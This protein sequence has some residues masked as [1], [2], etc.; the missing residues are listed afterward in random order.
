MRLGVGVCGA[1]DVE[2]EDAVVLDEHTEVKEIDEDRARSDE[3][4]WKEGRVDLAEVARE[5]SVLLKSYL[6]IPL[7]CERLRGWN[8]VF[9]LAMS[10]LFLNSPL[11]IVTFPFSSSS[12][13]RSLSSLL[14]LSGRPM[15]VSSPRKLES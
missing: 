15:L 11:T 4:I 10:S 8:G 3:N 6:A 13:Q 12:V 14:S 7:Q 2:D 9:T 5:E 1:E